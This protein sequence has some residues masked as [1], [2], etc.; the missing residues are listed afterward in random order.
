M[1]RLTDRLRESWLIVLSVLFFASGFTS[2]TFEVLWTRLLANVVGTTA[3]AMTCVFSIFVLSL[4]AGAALASRARVYGRRALVVYGGLESA[5]GVLGCLV[6]WGLL[7]YSTAIAHLLEQLPIGGSIL[8][9][10]LATVLL[11]GLPAT[12]M[13]ATFPMVLNGVKERDLP[14]RVV[15]RLYGVNV[16]G[17]AFG[18][19][20]TGFVLVW[21]LGVIGTALFA[22]GLN[23]CIALIAL[24]LAHPEPEAT[25]R[26]EADDIEPQPPVAPSYRRWWYLALAFL[27]GMAALQYE[28]LWGRLSKFLL[29]D[30]T[31][32]TAALLFIYLACLAFGSLEVRRVVGL[33]EK[34]GRLHPFAAWGMLVAAAAVGQLVAVTGVHAV[35]DGD[36]FAFLA[37]GNDAVGRVVVT[38]LLAF[39]PVG[40]LGLAFP[41]LMYSAR[42]INDLPGETVGRLYFVNSVGAAIGAVLGGY[43]LPRTV[44]TLVGFE[45]TSLML[46]LLGVVCVWRFSSAGRRAAIIAGIV[47]AFVA[48]FAMLPKNF[49]FYDSDDQLLDTHEDE[50]GIQVMTRDDDGHLNVKNNEISI[51]YKLGAKVTSYVQAML[52]Y[53]PCLMSTSC[54]RIFNIGTGYGITAG[55]FT[56][57]DGVERIETVEVLPYLYENQRKFEPYNFG[58]VDHPAVRRI[59]GDGRRV[60]TYADGEYDVIA[61]NV[62]DP[63]IPGSSRLFTTE[64]WRMA[65]R[66]LAPGGAY[67]QLLF[68][69]DNPLLVRGMKEVFGD[70]FLFPA[71][72]NAYIAIAFAKSGRE[73]TLRTDRITP[74]MREAMA[75]IGVEDP[76]TH[77]RKRL[78]RAAERANRL[79][80]K[81]PADAQL[82][83]ENWPILEYRWS[84][85]YSQ[86][87]MFDS[88][89]AYD[90][91]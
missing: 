35:I 65:R 56:H 91:E 30:R 32:A 58:Y 7:E 61:V 25:P 1:E 78:R 68:G 26:G 28:L 2:L 79:A 37:S 43:L 31:M 39:L 21:Q 48:S 19:L 36:M 5:I 64:F 33:R 69:S 62:L 71:Y 59:L 10:L 80:S 84:Q 60:L 3:V 51:A 8:Y 6:T 74:R 72:R 75:R 22:L 82:H 29:G 15:T 53:Q 9:A 88:L 90:Y 38:F 73:P 45:V 87:S 54:E 86:L 70:V 47:A 16:L 67:A 83:T 13:G 14:R 89:Q 27:C 20:A 81:V 66:K 11:V 12:L 44:G 42:E 24:G 49:F 34:T 76:E 23:L 4:S 77:L 17:G 18:A 46:A 85:G 57:V 41:Y 40:V 52:A 55:A 50:Y 63:Y